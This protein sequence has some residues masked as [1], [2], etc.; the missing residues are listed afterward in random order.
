METELTDA[1]KLERRRATI[2]RLADAGFYKYAAETFDLAAAQS[3]AAETGFLFRTAPERILCF[4]DY[5]EFIEGGA[6]KYAETILPQ[7]A[8]F[9]VP[10]VKRI[11][12]NWFSPEFPDEYS[13]TLD[14][15][16]HVLYEPPG[17]SEAWIFM[18]M[19]DRFLAKAGTDER[20]EINAV[21]EMV[22]LTAAQTE[23][24]KSADCFEDWT[25]YDAPEIED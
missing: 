5:E 16:R 20:V 21:D 15:A 2:A 3:D 4:F 23:I 12:Q 18:Q 22:L 14:G 24:L 25:N 7:L 8:R 9:G 19:L 13:I 17:D 10:T 6:K 1:Q 11:E